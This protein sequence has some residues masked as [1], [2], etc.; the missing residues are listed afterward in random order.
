MFYFKVIGYLCDLEK[1]VSF[2]K[3]NHDVAKQLI[4]IKWQFSS[5]TCNYKVT[6]Q[7]ISEN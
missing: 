2:C 6:G 5:K 4:F 3:Q 7:G 1:E